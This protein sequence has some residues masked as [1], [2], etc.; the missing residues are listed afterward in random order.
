[1]KAAY[2][3]MS[4]LPMINIETQKV[5]FNLPWIDKKTVDKAIRDFEITKT[6]WTNEL[7]RAKTDWNIDQYN[8]A[9]NVSTTECKVMIDTQKLI[10]SIDKN[11]AILNEYK[12][13]PEKINKMIKIKEVRINQIL[14]NIETITKITG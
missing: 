8:C 9:S 12:K 4:R 10:S 3:F 1:V 7:E 11:I 5:N 2:D 14:C 6:Q 13:F